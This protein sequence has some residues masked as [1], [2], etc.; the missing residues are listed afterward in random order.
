[1]RIERNFPK[2]ASGI[3]EIA[4]ITA[5]EHISCR[6]TDDGAGT[7]GHLNDG[8]DVRF[9]MAVPGERKA[10][11]SI[12]HAFKCDV[13]IFGEFIRRPHSNR[14]SACLEKADTIERLAFPL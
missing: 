14:A 6:L 11:E 4:A 1:M 5:P 8:I 9:R 2:M 7:M 13:R 10:T 12:R 3:G